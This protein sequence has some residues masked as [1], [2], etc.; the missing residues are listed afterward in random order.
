MAMRRILGGGGGNEEVLRIRF[1]NEGDQELRKAQKALK[2]I[3]A[4][5]KELNEAFERGAVHSSRYKERMKE[6]TQEQNRYASAIERTV[7]AEKAMPKAG[8]PFYAGRAIASAAQGGSAMGIA[9]NLF[10]ASR[11]AGGVGALAK[12]I[13]KLPVAL[14]GVAA[15]APLAT[16]AIVATGGALLLI[17]KGLKDAELGWSDLGRVMANT[18]P[19]KAAGNVLSDFRD[20]VAGTQTGQDLAGI[21]NGIGSIVHD[22]AN[23]A[24]GWDDATAAAKRYNDEQERLAAM[25][26]RA[27]KAIAKGQ[28]IVVGEQ[29]KAH[30]AG[31][32]FGEA[33]ASRGGVK[34]FE[35]VMEQLIKSDDKAAAANNRRMFGDLFDKASRGDEAA[36]QALVNAMGAAGI[37][38]TGMLDF[39][40]GD[41]FD[42]D[43]SRE[44]GP[45]RAMMTEGIARDAA[46]QEDFLNAQIEGDKAWRAFDA[47]AEADAVKAAERLASDQDAEILDQ[48]ALARMQLDKMGPGLSAPGVFDAGSFAQQVQA[49]GAANPVDLLKDQL[50]MAEKSYNEQKIQTR[51]LERAGRLGA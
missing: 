28:Q 37:D 25:A 40:F 31:G 47:K 1:K 36:A 3:E 50:E 41:T 45:T 2:A 20:A 17:N 24:L 38:T 19:V 29:A 21:W 10:F 22:T 30:E 6:L 35:G 7:K 12:D 32:R 14:A 8:G 49:G 16:T 13:A 26:E 51:I 43:P 4:E 23:L 15:A 48:F 46:D 44:V 18:T 9:N 34:G 39:A 11:S 27:E 42:A 33:F 5:Q